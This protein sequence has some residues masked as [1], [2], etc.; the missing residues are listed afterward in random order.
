VQFMMGQVKDH[1]NKPKEAAQFYRKG[2][3]VNEFS[4]MQTY[5]LAE[6]LRKSGDA[7]GSIVYY[8]KLITNLERATGE[9]GR[10]HMKQL[11]ASV[12]VGLALS[13]KDLK[14]KDQ[15][16]VEVKKA[17]QEDPQNKEAPGLLK[18]LETSK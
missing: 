13:Y 10:E 11:L 5:K 8:Q 18:E 15:A 7:K 12:R 14:Q 3:S 4:S 6:S 16:I 9:Y 2:L 1:F 17:L